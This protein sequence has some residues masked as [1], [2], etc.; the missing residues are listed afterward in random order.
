MK[1]I[2]YCKIISPFACL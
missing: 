1:K 2:V